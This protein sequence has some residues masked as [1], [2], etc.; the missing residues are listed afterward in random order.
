[1]YMDTVK[2]KKKSFKHFFK[3]VANEIHFNQLNYF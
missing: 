1:M 3:K 2:K